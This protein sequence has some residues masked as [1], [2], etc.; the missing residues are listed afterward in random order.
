MVIVAVFAN[1][2]APYPPNQSEALN[3]LAEPSMT[4]LF[5]TDWLG[6]DVFSRVVYGARLSV[7]ISVTVTLSGSLIG[8]S[9]GIIG[10]TIGGKFDNVTQRIF[11]VM[12]A[13]PGLLL[14]LAV[15]SALG[16]SVVTVVVALTIGVIPR[17]NRILRSAALTL[18]GADYV[19]ASAALGATRMRVMFRHIAPNTMAPWII[20]AAT[21]FGQVIVSEASLAFLGLGIPPPAPSWG[22]ALAASQTRFIQAPWLAIFPGI[23]MSVVVFGANLLGDALRDVLDPRLRGTKGSV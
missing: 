12:L 13:F 11:D 4:H 9:I 16:P 8:G 17:M 7:L 10:A 5:G 6:R 1:L 2:I 22:R 18:K 19:E 3:A 20:V 21:L 14:L 15:V 23:A